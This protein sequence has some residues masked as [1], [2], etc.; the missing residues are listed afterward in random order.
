MSTAAKWYD[1]VIGLDVHLAV[2]PPAAVPVPFPHL[3]VGIVLDVLAMMLDAATEMVVGGGGQVMI[4]GKRPGSTGTKVLAVVNRPVVPNAMTVRTG[5]ARGKILTGSRTVV[6]GGSL[7]ARM[8]SGV[9]TCSVPVDVMGSMIL[10][11]PSTVEIG[12]PEA[13]DGAV[14]IWMGIRTKWFSN[15]VHKVLRIKPGSRLSKLVC[16]LTGHPVDVVSGAVLTDAIDFELPGALPLV[17]ERNYC[18]RDVNVGALGAGWAHSLEAAVFINGERLVVQLEDGRRVAHP[19]LEVGEEVWEAVECYSLRRTGEDEYCL[20]YT[21][22]RALVFARVAEVEGGGPMVQV[23]DRNGNAIAL[24]YAGGKLSW[25][26]DSAGRR[27]RFVHDEAGRLTGVGYQRAGGVVELVGFEF[28]GEG[29]LAAVRDA[30]GRPFSYTYRGGVLVRETNRN[31]LSFHFEYDWH[32]PHGRC[33]RTWGDG[34]ILERRL[35]YDEHRRVTV[36]DD[37][38]GGRVHYFGNAAGLVDRMIDAE[39][40]EWRYEWD[41]E[42]LRKIAEVD[43]LGH[44]QAWEYDGRGNLLAYVDALGHAIRGRYSKLDLPVEVIDGRG[45][46][47]GR[48]YDGRGN[49]VRAVDPLGA[50]WEYRRDCR[51]DVVAVRDP[52][53]RAVRISRDAA[54]QVVAL[55]DREGHT[56]RFEYDECG[57]LM[58]RIGALGGETR[59]EW[60]ACGRVTAVVRA[61]RSRIGFEYD[62]EGNLV[63]RVDGLGHSWTYVYGG[64]NK[65]VSRADPLGGR[66]EYGYDSEENLVRVVNELGEVCT[67]EYDRCGQVVRAVGFD[68][69]AQSVRYDAAGREVAV[70]NGRRQRVAIVRDPV[71]RVVEQTGSDGAWLRFAYDADGA[72]VEAANGECVLRYVRDAC[73][74]VMEERAGEDVVESAFDALGNRVGRRTSSGH[75]VFYDYD[76]NGALI[77]LR[78]PRRSEAPADAPDFE[79]RDCWR[80]ELVRD[81]EGNEVARR[82]PG[83]VEVR[84][85]RDLLGRPVVQRVR[86]HARELLRRSYEWRAEDRLAAI[87]DG[88]RGTIRYVHDVRGALI[89]AEHADGR[90]E[91][92][93]FDL[94][95]N[96]F[97]A[98]DRSDRVYGPGGRLLTAGAASFEYDGDG[99]MTRRREGDGEW[100]YAWDSLGQLRAANSDEFLYDAL[101]RRI[102]RRGANGE[103]RWSWDGD[104]CVEEVREGE[105]RAWVLGGDALPLASVSANGEPTGR[106]ADL[107]G[108]AIAVEEDGAV[109]VVWLDICGA[110]EGEAI[111]PW[112]WP[113][114]YE[115]DGLG[116]FYNGFRFYD[117]EL[118]VY[119]S[120]DPAWAD[121]RAYGYVI[122][123]LGWCDPLGLEPRAKML[124]EALAVLRKHETSSKELFGEDVRI[125]I[126]GS[127]STGVKFS[128]GGPFNPRDFDVDAFVVPRKLGNG[129]PERLLGRKA[130]RKSMILEILIGEELRIIPE[131]A[132]VRLPFGFR[133]WK[134]Q[135]SGSTM[136]CGK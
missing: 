92:R 77:G 93:A 102:G 14:A 99:N 10:P 51:G 23:R 125:G 33:T 24:E 100:R 127:L 117:P 66:V 129:W 57:R 96:V 75:E 25:V 61:D 50:A 78:G 114:Q 11:F 112:R 44:R 49:L 8:L 72:V 113:G 111:G 90:V 118:G 62:S 29:R 134:Q 73:G 109:A 4:D 103:T 133:V 128:T 32:H 55:T 123:P 115:E 13:V 45:Q 136:A 131:F 65:V 101:G 86:R 85:E 83:D 76:R 120:Q 84:W 5:Q 43:P 68:G 82:L 74:R 70:V 97:R 16:F 17:F 124:R 94:A 89:A 9:K 15:L 98:G 121:L 132:K 37:S 35:T 36:V 12:G 56:T 122:D 95:G 106:V 107:A 42:S 18:S 46:R 47:W 6:I 71:G 104:E 40:G 116:I 39:G 108:E 48:E 19:W 67:F 41:P 38:R 60:D 135:P 79:V 64:F 88:E 63:R 126:R 21:S 58:R 52:L 130:Q 26:V 87:H 22:G 28:D 119:L 80:I 54:G 110:V 2:I 1:L 69:R 20:T 91:R 7:A 81:A 34:G 59:I 30:A 27:L 31:G 3:F 53:G 105:G